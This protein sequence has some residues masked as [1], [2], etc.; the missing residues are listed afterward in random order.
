MIMLSETSV[1]YEM[2][3]GMKAKWIIWSIVWVILF[4]FSKIPVNLT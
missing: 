1:P 3:E 2:S 4:L